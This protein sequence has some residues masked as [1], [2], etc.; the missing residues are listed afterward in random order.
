MARRAGRCHR[1]DRR[2]QEVLGERAGRGSSEGPCPRRLAAWRT[3]LGIAID[4]GWRGRIGDWRGSPPVDIPSR[5]L[6]AN[7]W[8]LRLCAATIADRFSGRALARLLDPFVARHFNDRSLQRLIDRPGPPLNYR[9]AAQ[10]HAQEGGQ[11]E[12]AGWAGLQN[13]FLNP[14]RFWA[15]YRLRV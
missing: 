12:Q 1:G 9:A 7:H 6:R 14:G 8:S 10:A 15:G 2:P 3:G 11:A 13:R 5:R 4:D